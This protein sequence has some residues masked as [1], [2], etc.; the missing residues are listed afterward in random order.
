L[1]QCDFVKNGYVLDA[2]TLEIF[3]S[4]HCIKQIGHAGR[5]IFHKNPTTFHKTLG[6]AVKEQIAMISKRKKMLKMI[7]INERKRDLQI[8]KAVT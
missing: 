5:H 8:Q 4:Y 1:S 2:E 7:S 6:G 3:N